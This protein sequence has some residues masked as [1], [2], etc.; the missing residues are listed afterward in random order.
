MTLDEILEAV[1]KLSPQGM[2]ILRERAGRRHQYSPQER[3]RM[4]R[5]AAEI[6]EGMTQAEL[7]EM[8]AMMDG[9]A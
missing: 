1:D 7:D 9:K 3:V 2:E 4:M 8:F 5:Q 6:R